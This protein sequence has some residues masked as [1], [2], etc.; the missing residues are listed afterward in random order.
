MRLGLGIGVGGNGRAGGEQL[1]GLAAWAG[2]V[3]P[4]GR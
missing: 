1:D 3:S 2:T 4:Q